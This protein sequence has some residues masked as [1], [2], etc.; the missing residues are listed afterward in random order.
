MK[1]QIGM[2]VVIASSFL[3]ATTVRAHEGHDKAFGTNTAVVSSSEKITVAPEG[4]EAMGIKSKPIKTGSVKQTLQATGR[5]EAAENHSFDITPTVSGMVKGVLQTWRSGLCWT[6][7]RHHIQ[8][9]SC[10]CVN[11]AIGGQ[12]EDPGRHR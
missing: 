2:A 9:R 8:S 7:T 6:N 5:V 12:S 3:A 11:Q 10:W 4:Q 1:V